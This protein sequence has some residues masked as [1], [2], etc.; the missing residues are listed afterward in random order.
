MPVQH[1]ALLM[2]LQLDFGWSSGFCDLNHSYWHIT[3]VEVPKWTAATVTA[4]AFTAISGYT[5]A[6]LCV[7]HCKINC[8]MY[9]KNTVL[10]LRLNQ[11]FSKNTNDHSL[12]HRS[13]IRTRSTL[14]Q[15]KSYWARYWDS[16]I[17]FPFLWS[18][19]HLNV[20]LPSPSQSSNRHILRSF[21]TRILCA[22]LVSITSAHSD[23][24]LFTDLIILSY[25]YTYNL[26]TDLI[27]LTYNHL[28]EH[29][30]FRQSCS[31]IKQINTKQLDEV[32]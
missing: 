27:P 6:G 15:P 16:S 8:N 29:V 22:L 14:L 1:C 26:L 10:M 31:S 5:F 24:L 9:I 32:S 19:I 13:Q 18:M 3:R 17:H 12:I 2:L 23:H 7:S 30:V 4:L 28:L 11:V 20:V 21:P 25:L